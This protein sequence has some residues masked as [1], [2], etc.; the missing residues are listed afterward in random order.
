MPPELAGQADS[1]ALASLGVVM[2]D[3]EMGEESTP[4]NPTELSE[5]PE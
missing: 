3:F 5:A 2:A 4:L 1:S